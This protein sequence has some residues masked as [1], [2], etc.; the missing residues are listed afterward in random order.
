MRL[1]SQLI[2]HNIHSHSR[3]WIQKKYLRSTHKYHN[4]STIIISHM[5][6][7]YILIYTDWLRDLLEVVY[8][9]TSTK[10]FLLQNFY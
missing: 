7:T 3:F 1:N 9:R 4:Y 6:H 5:I 8:Q 10:Y 2:N